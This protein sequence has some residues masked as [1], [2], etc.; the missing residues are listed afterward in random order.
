MI[1]IC[2]GFQVLANLGVL[3]ALDGNYKRPRVALVH[4]DN[5]CYTDR[6]V[7]LE[8]QNDS[9]WL[10]GVRD[11]S[12]PIAHGEGK[13]YASQATL[14]SLN[15]IGCVALRYVP[16]DIHREECLP[17]NPNGS[18]EDIAGITDGTRRVFGLMPHPERNIFDHHQPR[19]HRHLDEAR[20]NGKSFSHY[21]PGLQI[22]MNGVDY[23]K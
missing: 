4:N 18:L 20:L 19:Y 16:G 6:W 13:F 2:N 10:V 12:L 3:P 1:G 7:D 5:G 21:G 17:Y 23:F 8:R 15:E 14:H 11:I 22:F 9:P